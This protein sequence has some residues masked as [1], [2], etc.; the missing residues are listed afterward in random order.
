M[1]YAKASWYRDM[2]YSLAVCLL[3]VVLSEVNARLLP[4]KSLL[5]RLFPFTLC[6]SSHLF[7]I[8]FGL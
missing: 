8:L 3:T 2:S 7:Y 6:T 5:M 4:I 1:K